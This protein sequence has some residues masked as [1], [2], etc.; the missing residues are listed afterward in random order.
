MV[1][2]SFPL[3]FISIHALRVEGDL[4]IMPLLPPLS[5]SIHA[6]RVEGDGG[7]VF[8][9]S[10]LPVFLSTP[11]GW[12][13]TSRP[14]SRHPLIGFL[15]TPSGWRATVGMVYDM[16]IE[17][18]F[19]STPSGWRA[20]TIDL[21]ALIP[22]LISIHALRVEGDDVMEIVGKHLRIS[23]HALRVEGD[24]TPITTA[25]ARR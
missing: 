1:Y 22:K 17:Q 20:T 18:T 8:C 13:A 16:L 21:D 15:S 14:V 23:I 12:R 10:C 24:R 25:L 9:T 6:L 2:Y 4:P 11:S 3:I 7:V 5:I 19:L